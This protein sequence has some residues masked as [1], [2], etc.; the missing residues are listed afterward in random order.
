MSDNKNVAPPPVAVDENQIVA[1]RRG[2]LAA[3]RAQGAEEI[4]AEE[5]QSR[6]MTMLTAPPGRTASEPYLSAV[7]GPHWKPARQGHRRPINAIA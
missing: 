3:L 2:K 4:A 1:D 7:D 6:Q 5:A